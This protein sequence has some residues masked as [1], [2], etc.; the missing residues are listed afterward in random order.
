MKILT[1]NCGVTKSPLFCSRYHHFNVLEDNEDKVKADCDQEGVRQ[2]KGEKLIPEEKE[3]EKDMK[4]RKKKSLNKDPLRW[5]GL[6]PPSSLRR[7]QVVSMKNAIYNVL[8]I[9][10]FRH[11]L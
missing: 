4:E 11:I 1:P 8:H 9:T 3:E 10:I 7:A 5:F 2:R 6:M